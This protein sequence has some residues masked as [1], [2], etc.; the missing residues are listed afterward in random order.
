[1]K[2]TIRRAVHP[3]F[4]YSALAAAVLGYALVTPSIAQDATAAAAPSEAAAPVAELPA[5]EAPA[6]ALATAPSEQAEA[7]Q[8]PAATEAPA[9]TAAA[10]DDIEQVVVTARRIQERLQDVPISITVFNQE[11]L[12][13]RNILSGRDLATYTPSLAVNGR[14]GTENASFSLR[15]FSQE[16]RT[17][18]SVAVYFADV[19]APRGGGAG[20]PSGNGAGPGAFFDLQNVQVVKGPQGTLFGRNTTGGAI[21]LVPQKPTGVLGGF[22]EES[23]GNYGSVRTQA[24][25]NTPIS[26]N[27]RVRF[28]I[29]RNERDGY[30]NN[31]SGVGPDDF[32]NVD[33]TATRGSLVWDIAPSLENY[34]IASYSLSNTNGQVPQLFVCNPAANPARTPSAA[35]A[36]GQLAREGELGRFDVQ[37]DQANPQSRNERTQFINTTTWT[38]TD[39]LT[40]KNIISYAKL[41]NDLQGDLF[42]TNFFVNRTANGEPY[43]VVGNTS[44][45]PA[46]IHSADQSTFTEELQFQGTGVDGRWVWQAG[47]YY[48]SSD[49]VDPTGA[50]SPSNIS[51]KDASTLDCFDVI[52]E[53]RGL[54][55]S[56]NG[57]GG[58]GNV[59]W[60]VGTIDFRN[61]GIYTQSTFS[62][63]D[64][65]KATGGIRYTNDRAKS[66]SEIAYRY[67]QAPT[68]SNPT[69]F[70][71]NTASGHGFYEPVASVHDCDVKFSKGS[72]APTWILGLDYQVIQDLM[73]YGKY[74][75][76][77]REGG[78]QPFSA[79]GF[80][81]YNPEKVDTYEVGF[82]SSFRWPIKGTFN[83][84]AFY[85]DF[86]DQQLLFG[87]GST[88][89]APGN[90][91]ITNA[92]SSSIKGVEVETTLVPFKG[93]NVNLSYAFLDT[94][95]K[96]LT[97]LTM[98]PNSPYDI[99]V[100]LT[101]VGDPLPFSTRHKVSSSANYTLPLDR[102]IGQVSIGATYS[103]QAK[104]F[105]T[106]TKS[107]PYGELPAYSLVNANLAWNSIFGS[108]VDMALF[109]TNVLDKEYR[110]GITN[111]WSSFGFETQVPGEPRMYGARVRVNFGS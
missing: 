64:S 42:G 102:S 19:V 33:Y 85:N 56:A 48:E 37:S 74:S 29:D 69:T 22:A 6:S 82:K 58:Y 50:Q 40:I 107:N 108:S 20:T 84:A 96:E 62:L 52:G 4:E 18:P 111:S 106:N 109:A 28:G 51:C 26:E 72:E 54:Q 88:K 13:D 104:M 92:G 35:L 65:L 47:A 25:I 46:G 8:A 24:V 41:I 76:G 81:T 78:V 1:V 87:F 105:I 7:P 86:S 5:P 77:Y 68:Y 10:D 99:A 100:P 95:V 38:A 60:Q 71:G 103:Y 57:Y 43:Q 23:L 98:D 16:I 93:L 83:V 89:G 63:T 80:N 66:D 91:A 15:G 73:V 30:L 39:D 36:C 21:L 3:V 55:P 53:N 45:L 90:A 2:K 27:V 9:Q 101:V 110:A 79:P 97:A 11:Q 75:R 44:G 17:A 14:Y 67:F 70:C 61:V 32:Q 31:T 94:K 12:T 34:T 59:N 49:A